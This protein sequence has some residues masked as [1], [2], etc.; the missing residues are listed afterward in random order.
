MTQLNIH[1]RINLRYKYQRI[2]KSLIGKTSP[3][4]YAIWANKMFPT[5]SL[6]LASS[7]F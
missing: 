7:P 3:F 6:G 5:N 2:G 4:R 1:Q